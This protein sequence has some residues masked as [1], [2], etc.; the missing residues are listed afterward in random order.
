MPETTQRFEELADQLERNIQFNCHGF[1][2]KL[3]RS[4]ARQA[5]T[6]MGLTILTFSL[7]R[8]KK[9]RNDIGA[10]PHAPELLRGWCAILY[11][12]LEQHFDMQLSPNGISPGNTGAWIE[13]AEHC[14]DG[15]IRKVA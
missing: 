6:E 2:I 15:R 14:L 12:I 13:F 9:H 5:L 3:N 4:N 7:D 8:A 11:W 1:W 10:N